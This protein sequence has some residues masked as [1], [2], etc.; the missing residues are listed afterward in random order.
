MRCAFLNH[1]TIANLTHSIHRDL[2]K[3]IHRLGNEVGEECLRRDGNGFSILLSPR[4]LRVACDPIAMP[5][6]T[7]SISLWLLKRPFA[8]NDQSVSEADIELRI[9]LPIQLLLS[10]QHLKKY[11]IYRLRLHVSENE[12]AVGELSIPDNPLY[13]GYIG[14]TKRHFY[15]RFKEH[16]SAALKGGSTTLYRTWNY[17]LNQS[18]NHYPALQLITSAPTLDDAYAIEEQLVG[19]KTLTPLGL[20][21]IPGGMAGIRMLHE[22]RLLSGTNQIA[23]SDRDAALEALERFGDRSSP[24]VHF[25]S[26][27]PRRLPTGHLTWVRPCWVNPSA[28]AA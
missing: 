19:E 6:G 27:H 9:D 28:E 25:R 18:V 26:G 8:C 16:R 17:L 10:P 14:I 24:C 15:A 20:N 23:V 12:N 11:H 13:R 3:A 21:T 7:D 4:D 2:G 5:P 22:L 1:A